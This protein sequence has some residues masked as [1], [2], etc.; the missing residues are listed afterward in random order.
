MK[1]KPF[2]FD[3]TLRI[4]FVLM[5]FCFCAVIA[6]P[7]ALGQEPVWKG[8]MPEVTGAFGTIAEKFHESQV[9]LKPEKEEPEWWAGA[10]SVVRDKDGVFWMACRMRSPEHP[11]GLRGYEIRILRS[12]DG[13]QFEKVHAIRREEIPIPGFERPCLLIDR[14]TEKFKLYACGPWAGGPWSIIRFDDAESPAEFIAKTARPVIQPVPKTYERDI[15]TK[16]YKDPFILQAEGFYHAYVIGVMRRTERIYHFRS[17]DGENWEPVGSPYES[18][19]N[20][21]GWHDFYV[22]PASVLPLG[23]GYLF[24]YEGSNVTWYDPVYNIG[25]GIGFTFD[26]HRI[27]DLTPDSPLVL[28]PVPGD[29]FAT[30]RYT[31]WMV[32]DDEIWVYAEVAT[33]KGFHEIRLFRVE[34]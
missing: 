5:S 10:P 2:A 8:P 12:E 6:V 27:T 30:C 34:K 19:M 13:V 31:H 16:E 1:M 21:D 22:R 23:V 17:R 28:S 9:I 3:E 11:R 33:P 24:L 4:I 15:I 26:L 20:L 14:E 7:A 18:I 32:V 25:T 29:R